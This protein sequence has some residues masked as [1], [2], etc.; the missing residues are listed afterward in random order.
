MKDIHAPILSARPVFCCALL[1]VFYF[2]FSVP[3]RAQSTTSEA[4]PPGGTPS[5]GTRGDGDDIQCRINNILN[6]NQTLMTTLKNKMGSC[7]GP[8][9]NL[10]TD[11][12][13]RGMAAQSHAMKANA[14]MKGSDYSG[15]NTLRKNTCAGKKTDCATGNGSYTGGDTDPTVGSDTADQLDSASNALDT[16]N[17]NLSSE[18]DVAPSPSPAAAQATF[19][20]LY[21]YTADSDYPAWL[22]TGHPD[23]KALVASKF[24]LLLAAQAADGVKEVSE[25][26]CKQDAVVLGE[27]GNGSL[28][29]MVLSIVSVAIDASHE[30]LEF[31]DNDTTAWEV[32]GAYE[33]AADLNTN[34]GHVDSDV[35]SVQAAVGNTEALIANL[36]G[37]VTTLQNSVTAL[38]TQLTSVAKQLGQKLYV[39]TDMNKQIIQLLLVPDGS[40]KVGTS[41]LTCNGDGSASAPCPP[42]ILNCSVATGQC[43]FNSH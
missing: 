38:Q 10:L 20:D 8:H 29:C 35:S 36:Q 2:A 16:A 33:R 5:T 15:L 7:T 12:I 1:A 26:A 19:Q 30:I 31:V 25:D 42:V 11:S 18:P 41:L 34:L 28:A 9:C 22:H 37:Q 13:N 39:T 4:C 17:T 27:G 14:R 43:S 3:L 21:D 32:H 6:S 24:A 23:P 40:R